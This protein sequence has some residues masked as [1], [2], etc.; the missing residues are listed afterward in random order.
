M[1]FFH[2]DRMIKGH[3]PDTIDENVKKTA[4]KK[5]VEPNLY[6]LCLN[7]EHFYL[8]YTPN[9]EFLFNY[10]LRNNTQ[11]KNWY[12]NAA[13]FYDQQSEFSFCLNL[14]G[15]WKMIRSLKILGDFS[16]AQFDRGVP[17]TNPDIEGVLKI[18]P[19]QAEDRVSYEDIYFKHLGDQ[20][21]QELE[22]LSG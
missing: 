8:P 10:L 15:V 4:N 21:S 20:V 13:S 17:H 6:N 3:Q 19:Q 22:K 16:L 1:I 14:E 9:L 18:T 2:K 5:E 7:I 11:L 12:K